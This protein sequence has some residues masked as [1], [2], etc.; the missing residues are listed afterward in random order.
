MENKK[1]L[2]QKFD[3]TL[4]HGVNKVVKA[5]NW[6]TGKTKS[7]LANLMLD[8]SLIS[9]NAGG[10]LL[11]PYLSPVMALGTL[12]IV[13]N[14]QK[15]NVEIDERESIAAEK[16]LKDPIAET[17]KET[18]K[19]KGNFRIAFSTIYIPFYMSRDPTAVDKNAG[20][21][22]TGAGFLMWG[23][24][25]NIMRAD[26]YPPQKNCISRG[27]DKL[28]EIIDNATKQPGLASIPI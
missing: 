12:P 10:F 6:T 16:G 7:D 3:D 24:A 20:E 4:M 25:D 17:Y 13:H 8:A 9:I 28:T 5:W 23:V 15:T 22:L 14:E 27:L 26:Y 19:A 18:N 2:Y 11:V 21:V 1:D